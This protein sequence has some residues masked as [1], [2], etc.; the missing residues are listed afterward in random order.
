MSQDKDVT[1]PDPQEALVCLD[2]RRPVPIASAPSNG[3]VER[4]DVLGGLIHD[5]KRRAA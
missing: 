2:R 4:R 1:A 5:D 3:V